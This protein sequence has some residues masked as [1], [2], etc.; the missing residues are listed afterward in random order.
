M[1]TTCLP[2]APD[3][4][5]DLLAERGPVGLRQELH[6]LVDAAELA[7]GDR[8]VAGDGGADGEHDGVEALDELRR[9]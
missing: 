1:I 4:A 9:R 6:R 3:L 2:V 7:P 5:L 8:Q